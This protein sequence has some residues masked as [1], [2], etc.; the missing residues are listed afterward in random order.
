MACRKS[1]SVDESLPSS[2]HASVDPVR[3]AG[4]LRF[5]YARGTAEIEEGLDRLRRF[6]E[7]RG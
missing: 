2:S 6:M 7:T 3:G 5:S 4:T 1:S